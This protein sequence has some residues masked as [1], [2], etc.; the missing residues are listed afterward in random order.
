MGSLI[1]IEQGKAKIP[2]NLAIAVGFFC[3]AGGLAAVV[4]VNFDVVVAK[5]A[6]PDGGVCVATG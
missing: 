6:G 3:G 4:G 1:S 5:V 2:P